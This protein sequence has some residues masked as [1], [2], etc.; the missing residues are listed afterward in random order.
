M[1]GITNS[2]PKVMQFLVPAIKAKEDFR[3]QIFFFFW[4]ISFSNSNSTQ[5]EIERKK[6][7]YTKDI[8]QHT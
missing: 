2:K 6:T 8:Q 4:Y 1:E 7:T 5:R 3:S